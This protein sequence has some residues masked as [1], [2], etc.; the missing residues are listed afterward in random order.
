[1]GEFKELINVIDKYNDI[2]TKCNSY[3]NEPTKEEVNYVCGISFEMAKALVLNYPDTAIKVAKMILA[4]KELDANDI[5]VK[6]E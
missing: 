2:L 3:K 6:V 1:M 5:R 4:Y